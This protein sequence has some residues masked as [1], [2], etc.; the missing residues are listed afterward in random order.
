MIGMLLRMNDHWT[1]VGD[2]VKRGR[3]ISRKGLGLGSLKGYYS[4]NK[5]YNIYHDCLICAKSFNKANTNDARE[6]L[7]RPC[8]A[9]IPIQVRHIH[10]YFGKRCFSCSTRFSSKNTMQD[11][12]KILCDSCHVHEKFV[13]DS[14]NCSAIGCS[15]IIV[16]QLELKKLVL[17][18][19]ENSNKCYDCRFL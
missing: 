13:Y 10:A 3:R 6:L 16:P 8:F 15:K 12:T 17:G 4:R 11:S 2:D 7:C 9:K 14:A 19:S 5:Q 1:H 18:F